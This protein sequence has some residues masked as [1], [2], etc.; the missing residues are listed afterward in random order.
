M[1]LF[2]ND[3]NLIQ[4][5]IN[6][7]TIISF[8]TSTILGINEFRRSRK[9]LK[10]TII[11]YDK[12]DNSKIALLFLCVENKSSSPIAIT[13][14]SI[15]QG[16]HRHICSLI[17]EPVIFMNDTPQI[18]SPNFPLNFSSLEAL[19]C[20]LI[21]HEC[22]EIQLHQGN[23]IHLLICTNRGKIDKY[24]VLPQQSSY[25]NISF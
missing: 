11:D 13:S 25:L 16:A 5:V 23:R 19:N 2:T 21:F 20:L 12:T 4:S 1:N 3:S 9:K 8:C 14:I 17:S 22:K 10:I 15:V 6:V 18:T 7:M 24:L